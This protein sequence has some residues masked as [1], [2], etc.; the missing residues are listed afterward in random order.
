MLPRSLESKIVLSNSL[1]T[2]ADEI[3]SDFFIDVFINFVDD[4]LCCVLSDSELLK[5]ELY[6][7]YVKLIYYLGFLTL[8]NSDTDNFFFAHQYK[9]YVP[10]RSPSRKRSWPV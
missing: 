3:F 5:R 2:T 7:C 10:K 6:Y 4:C 9:L 8:S 1:F